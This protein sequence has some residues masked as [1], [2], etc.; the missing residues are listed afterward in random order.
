MQ[1][2]AET[3]LLHLRDE[4]RAFVHL[5]DWEQFHE[6]RNLASAIAIEAAELQELFLW[7]TD[8]ESASLLDD[9]SILQAIRNELADILILCL[10]FANRLNIDLAEAVRS[11]MALNDQKYPAERVRGKALK[12]THFRDE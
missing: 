11:K 1:M 9:Q 8:Q 6:P 5:R 10:S 3:T 4:V 7:T 12:Y 2:D